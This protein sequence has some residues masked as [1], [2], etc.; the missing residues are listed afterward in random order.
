VFN[1]QA[2]D[3]EAPV[4][5]IAIARHIQQERRMVIWPRMTRPEVR[6]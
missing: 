4:T 2:I 1:H 3:V 5:V 6:R